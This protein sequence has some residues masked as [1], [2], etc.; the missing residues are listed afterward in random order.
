MRR[1]RRWAEASAFNRKQAPFT[2][3]AFEMLTFAF[4]EGQA[5]AG[6]QV[7]DCTR[8]ENFARFGQGRHTGT[9]MNRYSAEILPDDYTFARVQ[10]CSHLDPERAHTVGDR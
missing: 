6:N 5:G 2:G 9:D 8:Y 4:S 1:I 10:T 3:H 7:F